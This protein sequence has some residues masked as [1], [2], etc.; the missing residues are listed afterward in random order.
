MALWI[1][2]FILAGLGA[3]AVWLFN[4]LV[5]A[6]Q[7]AE[8]GWSDIDV[9]LRRRADLIP[10]LVA[11]VKGVAAHERALFAEVTEQRAKALSAGNDLPARADAEKQL[12]R[13][14]A[15]LFAI[16][17]DYP[18]LRASENFLELQHELSETEEKIEMARRFY[19]GA[20]REYNTKAETFPGSLIAGIFGFSRR[21]YFE[22]DVTGLPDVE[23]GT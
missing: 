22:T 9:Q 14:E 15:R 16:A 23:F 19:N 20:T 11:T 13:G 21:D 2:L 5:A 17:E 6:R 1:F 18:D 10:Q 8:N 12:A 3:L 4:R 7:M